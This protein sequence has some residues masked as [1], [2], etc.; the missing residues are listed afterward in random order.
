M[1]SPKYN[2]LPER[3]TVVFTVKTFSAFSPCQITGFFHI[4]D[5]AKDLTRVGSTGAGVNIEHGVT[6]TV[7]VREAS[8][9]KTSVKL[10]GRPLSDPV[11][12]RRV[13][14]EY[15]ASERRPWKVYVE[16]LCRLPVGTGYGTSGGGAASLSLALNNALGDP[17][18]RSESLSI[19]HVADAGATA[20]LGTVASVSKGGFVVRVKP[21]APGLGE[22]RR[23]SLPGSLRVVSGSFGPMSKS[24]VLSSLSLRHRVNLCSRRL[25][26][27]LL[28]RP[29]AENFVRLSRKFADC[30]G[31][32]SSRLRRVLDSTDREGVIASMMMLGDGAF[33]LV[34][35]DRVPGISR[36]FRR[37]G[38]LTVASR[39]Y[40]KGAH[41]I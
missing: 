18:S 32:V 33:C 24:L 38:L 30:L 26:R 2:R 13:V 7:S 39:I 29:D 8:R 20:G 17:L 34:P 6:T 11:V 16:H 3:T 12:S 14:D 10:N 1:E 19:A 37:E 23:L 9:Q 28:G 15:M 36:L 25:V 21:G 22:V 41:V 5:K 35:S 31:L 27:S 4:H 40:Q